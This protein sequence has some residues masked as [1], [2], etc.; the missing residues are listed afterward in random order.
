MFTIQRAAK[1]PYSAQQMFKLVNDIESYPE[2]MSGCLAA[3]IISDGNGWRE[4]RLTLGH[5][6]IGQ[7]FVTHNVLHPPKRMEIKLVKGPFSQFQGCWSFDAIGD[8]HC[9]VKLNLKFDFNNALL[10]VTAGRLLEKI[11]SR[12]VDE[13]CQRAHSLY[14]KPIN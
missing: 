4:A 7:S 14:K 10:K 13:L 12:Q 8:N 5:K 11:A 3:E 2:F 9:E 6:G 1:V